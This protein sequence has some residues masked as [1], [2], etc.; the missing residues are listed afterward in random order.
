RAARG[1]GSKFVSSR[2][3]VRDLDR[4]R[5]EHSSR[6]GTVRAPAEDEWKPSGT[7]SASQVA[8]WLKIFGE[9]PL[10]D[11]DEIDQPLAASP[12]GTT[13]KPKP[14]PASRRRSRRAR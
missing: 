14:K 6:G 8:H 13:P 4:R 2:D 11:P 3:F 10:F 9:V 5:G 1:C 12:T 7:V